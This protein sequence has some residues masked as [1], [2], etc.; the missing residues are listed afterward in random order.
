[1]YNEV[2][3]VLK[4]A[5]YK[6]VDERVDDPIPGTIKLIL[7]DFSLI[8]QTFD[9]VALAW[10]FT[11]YMRQHTPTVLREEVEKIANILNL[12]F[13]TMLSFTASFDPDTITATMVASFRV[14]KSK[15]YAS[16]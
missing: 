14:E 2:A 3:T 15:D 13:P 6:V 16:T 12:E 10:E 7:T 11:M 9:R 8:P 1:M 5:G 4:N